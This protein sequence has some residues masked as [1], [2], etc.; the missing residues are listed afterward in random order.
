VISEQNKSR[1]KNKSQ[2]LWDAQKVVGKKCLNLNIIPPNSFIH[3]TDQQILINP[4]VDFLYPSIYMFDV[5]LE[6]NFGDDPARPFIFDIEG[7]CPGLVV[8]N[9]QH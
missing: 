2:F 7:T 9:I 1:K 4:S 6:A 3:F 8:E 5:S